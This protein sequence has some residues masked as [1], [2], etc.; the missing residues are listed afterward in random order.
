ME[1][2]NIPANTCLFVTLHHGP[3]MFYVTQ[4]SAS[5]NSLK[6]C[7]KNSNSITNPQSKV[8]T[9][10]YTPTFNIKF[11]CSLIKRSI[12]RYR[13]IISDNQGTFIVSYA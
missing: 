11:I 3:I 4:D 6:V 8:I 7:K 2:S 13:R 5:L 9:A 12:T 1:H 10:A